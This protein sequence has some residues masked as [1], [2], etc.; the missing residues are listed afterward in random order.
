[1]AI[2]GNVFALG[3]GGEGGILTAALDTYVYVFIPGKKG[4]RIVINDLHAQSKDSAST[5]EYIKCMRVLGRAAI[6]AA[7]TAAGT[8]AFTISTADFAFGLDSG[9]FNH[10]A[11]DSLAADDWVAV[12]QG[13]DVWTFDQVAGVDTDGVVSIDTGLEE[14][15]AIGD[16]VYIFGT[17]DEN[18]HMALRLTNAGA[19]SYFDCAAGDEKGDPMLIINSPTSSTG[20]LAAGQSITNVSYSYVNK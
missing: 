4:G 7:G 20:S 13:G 16:M 2:D 14:I 19:D 8:S 1:M 5:A 9:N 17:P 18:A 10:D 15:P 11:T 6:T 12:D 3:V